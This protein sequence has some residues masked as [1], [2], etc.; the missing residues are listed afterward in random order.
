MDIYLDDL[1]IYSDTIEDYMR[2]LRTI[3]N[4]L[5]KEKFYLSEH[6]MQ[7]FQKE[8]KILRHIVNNQGIRMDSH[9]VESIKQWKVPTNKDLLQGFLGSVNYL[10]LNILQLHITTGILFKIARDTVFFR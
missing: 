1:V 3:I 9:K 7:L 10:T 8:L 5:C 6:K 4:I 2:H